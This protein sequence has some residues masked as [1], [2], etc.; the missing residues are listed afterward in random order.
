MDTLALGFCN[1]DV[2]KDDNNDNDM[3]DNDNDND[4]DAV[5]RARNAYGNETDDNMAVQVLM[6]PTKV[7]RKKERRQERA[8]LEKEGSKRR[9]EGL[10]RNFLLVDKRTRQ[11]YG[12][13]VG[14]WKKKLMLLSTDLDPEIGNINKQPEGIVSEIVE[15][16]Q[17]TWE[18]SFPMKFEYVEEVIA[19]NVTL[20]RVDLWK[21]IRNGQ[22]KPHGVSDRSW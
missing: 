11:P 3:I 13:G 2:N 1:D 18:Y 20:R 17:E 5:H 7:E 22:S 8:L 16:I 21:K 9:K 4:G 10:R 15:W 19:R 14:D 6:Y 12:V